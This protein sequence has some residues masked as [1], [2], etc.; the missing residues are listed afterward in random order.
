MVEQIAKR[1]LGLLDGYPTPT[2]MR[3]ALKRLRTKITAA[4]KAIFDC[5]EATANHIDFAN[6]VAHQS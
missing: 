6:I 1:A 4:R 2:E 5:D 3:A